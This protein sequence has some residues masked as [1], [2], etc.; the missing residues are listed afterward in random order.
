MANTNP[1]C[2]HCHKRHAT[3]A[4]CK[5]D[6]VAKDFIETPRSVQTLRIKERLDGLNDIIAA[7]RKH[8]SAGAKIKEVN[9]AIVLWAIK[10]SK[11]RKVG[12]PARFFFEWIEPNAKRDPDNII[13]AKKFIFDALQHKANQIIKGDGMKQVLEIVDTW[14]VTD[15]PAEVGVIVT[16]EEA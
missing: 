10:E 13:S 9:D 7:N 15:N 5:F 14:R 4:N 16:I 8:W 12:G 11:L 6:D 3:D 2:P 1:V